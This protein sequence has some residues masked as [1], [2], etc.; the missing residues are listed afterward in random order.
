MAVYLTEDDTDTEIMTARAEQIMKDMNLNHDLLYVDHMRDT[1][2][3]VERFWLTLKWS[4]RNRPRTSEVRNMAQIKIVIKATLEDGVSID[5]VTKALTE[6]DC[7]DLDE[8]IDIQS[9]KIKSVDE[10]A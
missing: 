10:D 2:G 4:S 6:G 3:D 8:A 9:V 1:V 5:D 7:G